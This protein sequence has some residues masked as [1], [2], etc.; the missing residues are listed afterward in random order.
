VKVNGKGNIL[1]C[2]EVVEKERGGI[3]EGIE[4]MGRV[5]GGGGEEGG[6]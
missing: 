4:S 5:G 1:L 6:Y 2:G 3:D